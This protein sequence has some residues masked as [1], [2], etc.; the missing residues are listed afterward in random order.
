M[1]LV[2]SF[3]ILVSP[4]AAQS[5]RV[6]S[7]LDR[8]I[9]NWNKA[10]QTI[11]NAPPGD[12][13]LIALISRCRLTPPHATAAE[14]AVTAAGWITFAYFDQKL[15][16]DDVEIVSAVRGADG[17]CRPWT[18]NLFVFVGE[19]F[20]GL[21]APSPMTSRLDGSSG[22]VRLPLPNVTAEFARYTSNDPL[23][24]PSAHVTVRY[25]I[26]RTPGGPLVVPIDIRTRG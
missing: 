15:I 12:E 19:R 6:N 25:R 4:A 18:Y 10:G 16:R 14:R 13:T 21:L 20:A 5:G 11:P 3:L 24:C 22:A 9:S 1:R 7:W 23:C 2:A 17:M 8:P 26:D